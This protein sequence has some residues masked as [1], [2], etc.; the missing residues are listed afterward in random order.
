MTIIKKYSTNTFSLNFFKKFVIIYIDKSTNVWR[1]NEDMW[2]WVIDRLKLM[3]EW[4]SLLSSEVYGFR[5]RF[6]QKDWAISK[7][8]NQ[9]A[10]IMANDQSHCWNSLTP[11]IM[12]LL[13]F[14]DDSQIIDG[15]EL[16]AQRINRIREYNF[17]KKIILIRSC[18]LKNWIY[19]SFSEYV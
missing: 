17:F 13:Q 14:P 9:N 5:G 15:R 3:N 1:M 7:W 8:T 11:W 6:I 16:D 10:G 4:M 18:T 12:A 19:L 2:V